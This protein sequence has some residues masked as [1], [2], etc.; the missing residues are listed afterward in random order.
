MDEMTGGGENTLWN[1]KR[2][3]GQGKLIHACKKPNLTLIHAFRVCVCVFVLF[4]IWGA[5][6]RHQATELLWL[7]S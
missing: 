4:A 3:R 1:R 7:I 5:V 6:H 2:R